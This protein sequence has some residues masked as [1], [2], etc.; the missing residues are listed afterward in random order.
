MTGYYGNSGLKPPVWTWE[1]PLYFFVG[2][3]AGMAS[4]IAFGAL[5]SLAISVITGGAST[6]PLTADIVRHALWLSA[7]GAILSPI[8]LASDLGR[9]RRFLNMLRVFK[10]R[11]P[12]SVGAWTLVLFGAAASVAFVISEGLARAI[13]P[14]SNGAGILLL[15]ATAAAAL[16]GALLATY[17][18]VLLG[19]TAVPAWNRHR[20]L[21]PAHFGAAGLGC[22]ACALQVMGQAAAPLGVIALIAAAAESV[23][24]IAM[25]LTRHGARD[26]A[27]R[28]GSSGAA[29]RSASFL[30]GPLSLVLRVMHLPI[31]SSMAFLLGALISRYAW[32]AVGRSSAKDPEANLSA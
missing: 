15:F 3:T 29:I 10:W 11:S 19:A 21:L 27:L 26:R 32:L 31:A 24:W 25:E 13:F 6:A 5:A 20:T 4:V 30:A 23:F 7:A 28:V 22:A 18:G 8:L 2:G 12:M 1:V 17:T 16:T 9:P 14:L